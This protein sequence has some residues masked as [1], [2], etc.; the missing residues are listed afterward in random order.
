MPRL[1][2]GLEVP[3]DVAQALALKKGALRKSRWIEPSEYHIT[4]RFVGD[5]EVPV[6]EALQAG[7][8]AAKARPPFT[9]TLNGLAA[10]GGNKPHSIYA[11]VASN[12][13]LSD[14]KAEHEQIAR[15]AGIGP[16]PKKFVPH[17]TLARLSRG[18]EPPAVAAYLGESGFFAPLSFQVERVVLFSARESTGG[19]PY[20][21]EA[22]YPLI[23][24]GAPPAA[25]D[26]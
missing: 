17:V 9:V 4:L 25:S 5:V 19:G 24:T 13:E 1:F 18:S 16:E 3:S 10:F 26:A 2:T 15:Q 8:A 14:L 12:R 22:A 23:A 20:V 21:V 11:S 6:A 7:L